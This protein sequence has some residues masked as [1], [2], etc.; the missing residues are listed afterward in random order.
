MR[1][2]WR[3][4]PR[5]NRRVG[6]FS[7]R[8][9]SPRLASKGDSFR[10]TAKS[11]S[12][13]AVGISL[14]GSKTTAATPRN[15]LLAACSPGS[16]PRRTAPCRRRSAVW[17][18]G[19]PRSVPRLARYSFGVIRWRWPPTATPP[20][21]RRKKSV[22]CSGG[23][24]TNAPSSAPTASRRRPFV[25]SRF[26]RWRRASGKSSN[27]RIAAT[28]RRSPPA[29]PFAPWPSANRCRT[30]RSRSSVSSANAIAG[31]I[32]DSTHSTR[33][34]PTVSRIRAA[35]RPFGV[36]SPTFGTVPSPT[37]NGNC[38]E[39]CLTVCSRKSFLRRNSGTTCCRSRSNSSGVTTVSGCSA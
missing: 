23:C 24:G 3:R 9:C 5:R 13:S 32:S 26:L 31:E 27:P 25:R 21:I 18:A 33:I 37:E 35:T 22:C 8:G 11:P 36:C 29:S 38:W 15:C 30:F 10:R 14:A 19:S 28:P 39:H 1:T 20:A 16:P 2:G 4:P 12:S 6:R 17:R 7:V 34:S